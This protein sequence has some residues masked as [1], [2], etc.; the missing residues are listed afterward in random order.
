MIGQLIEDLAIANIKLYML[1]DMKADVAANPDNYSK[2][3]IVKMN[4]QDIALCKRRAQL[5]SRID[6]ALSQAII[7]GEMGVVEEI[8]RY[9]S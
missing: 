1:C 9:G 3:A 4:A 2:E 6:S 5:K 7:K 8:K